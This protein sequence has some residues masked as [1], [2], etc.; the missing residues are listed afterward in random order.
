MN[1][2][3]SSAW[4]EARKMK[5][6]GSRIAS[7]LSTKNAFQTRAQ[8]MQEFLNDYHGIPKESVSE[9]TQKIFD[10]GNEHEQDAIRMFE[11]QF[12]CEVRHHGF[13]PH[14]DIDYIGMSPDGT[15]VL[16]DGTKVLVEAKC[17]WSGQVPD[18]VPAYYEDQC[19]LGMEVMNIDHAILCYWTI[20]GYGNEHLETFK[21]R[22]NPEWWA[23]AKAEAAKF[24]EEFQEKA[25]EPLVA[26]DVIDD[27]D[28]LELAEQLVH[29]VSE[30]NAL[31]KLEAEIKKQLKSNVKE[32]HETHIGRWN[33]VPITRKGSI[34]MDKVA[35]QLDQF[36]L[37]IEDYRQADK[38]VMTFKLEKTN[39]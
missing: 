4:L 33:I 13:I 27:P 30:K 37:D 19:Q 11:E 14:P 12:N 21:M 10:W 18:E 24:Y 22:R 20:D 6:S 3:G 29:V 34:D 17:P 38:T 1:E 9:F 2:Q 31:A 32:N 23:K 8:L 36:S 26:P 35:E 15:A 5:I 16:P 25:Q 28:L 39:D 7:V